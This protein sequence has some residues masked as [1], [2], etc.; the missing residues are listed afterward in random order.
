MK[1][2]V[3]S[4]EVRGLLR[5]VRVVD[6]NRIV[7]EQQ[8]DRAQYVKLN[9]VLSSLGG[10]WSRKDKAHVFAQPASELRAELAKIVDKGSVALDAD[11][12]WFPTPQA[13]A[14]R[15]VRELGPLEGRALLEPSAGEGSLAVA[16]REAG[17]QVTCIELHKGR[18]QS[19]AKLGFEVHQADF[20]TV[21]PRPFDVVLMNPP[22]LNSHDIEHVCHAMKFLNPGGVLLSVMSVGVEFRSTRKAVEFRKTLAAG[23]NVMTKLP[24]NSFRDS[25]TSVSTVFV[26]YTKPQR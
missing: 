9:D 20:L 1:E 14:Q 22:F 19:L 10:K 5:G 8:L 3:I 4:E 21:E 26:K 24:D 6:P 15:L 25:G 18:A 12:G 11:Y 13:L 23:G 7:I 16:A 17:A 2:T